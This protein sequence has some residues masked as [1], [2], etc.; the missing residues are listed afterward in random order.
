MIIYIAFNPK[1]L[2]KLFKCILIFYL[3]S[4]VFGGAAF[5][6][7]YIVKPQEILRNNGLVLNSHSLKVIFISAIIA[8]VII[9]IGFKIVKNKISSKDMYCYIK[10]KSYLCRHIT[11]NTDKHELYGH[12]HRTGDIPYHRTFPSI[13]HQRGILF[14]HQMLVGFSCRRYCMCR[15]IPLP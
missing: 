4:F 2:K 15:S 12:P 9:T 5:A 7:I 8:F 6:L 13:G 10:I 1:T 14:R 11:N 3:T